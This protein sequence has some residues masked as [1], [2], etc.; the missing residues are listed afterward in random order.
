MFSAWIL[1]CM[2]IRLILKHILYVN[3]LSTGS[4]FLP[5]K[6]TFNADILKKK[7]ELR[8]MPLTIMQLALILLIMI[9]KNIKQFLL[10]L[11]QK[12]EHRVKIP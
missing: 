3:A 10:L 12:L 11:H 4:S 8:F 1:I 7:R 6:L 2:V 5:I 9:K